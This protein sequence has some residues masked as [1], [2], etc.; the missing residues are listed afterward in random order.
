MKKPF[1]SIFFTIQLIVACIALSDAA[2]AWEYKLLRHTDPIEGVYSDFVIGVCTA[3]EENFK[4]YKDRP[5][6]MAC[7]RELDP[8][9]GFTR[10]K[11]ERLDILKHQELAMAIIHYRKWDVNLGPDPRPWPERLKHMVEKEN[12]TMD[13][14]RLDL[15]RDGKPDNLVRFGFDRPCDAKELAEKGVSS[16]GGRILY[17]IDSTL[18]K[19]DPYTGRGVDTSPLDDVFLFKG[20]V[21]TDEFW[22]MPLPAR[23]HAKKDGTLGVIEFNQHGAA[24]LCA[25]RY[26]D[27]TPSKGER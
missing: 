19:V 24:Q 13:I 4:K 17:V 14:V 20:I 5:Y 23:S 11:W 12:L 25:F 26:F 10:P 8:A 21:Y 15:N 27:S 18:T 9:L 16:G 1:F 22:S 6:G 7:K 3:M 2:H